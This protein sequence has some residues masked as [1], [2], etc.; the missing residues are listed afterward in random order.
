M[1]RF[2]RHLLLGTLLIISTTSM[3]TAQ[4]NNG[5]KE[6]TLSE[7]PISLRLPLQKEVIV[8]FP[9]PVTHTDLQDQSKVNAFTNLLTPDG[10][11]Y[12]RAV[13]AF[14]PTR[15]IAQLVDGRLVMLDVSGATMGPYDGDLLIRDPAAQPIAQEPAKNPYKP[16]FLED[17]AAKTLNMA[18]GDLGGAATV[19]S[20]DAEFHQMVRYGFRHFVGP[21]RLI[22][23]DLGKPVKVGKSDVA[24]TLLRMNDGRLSVKAL[25]QWEIGDYYLTVLLVNN[26]SPSAVEFDP[27]TIRGRWVFAAALY[28]V[29]EARGS[30]FDQTLWALIS[31]VPFDKARQ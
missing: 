18:E 23:D 13:E 31:Q 19:Q 5:V 1:K 4:Q 28:P 22:G 26:K 3:T 20:G 10:V 16:A 24:A 29:L 30:R 17:G 7:K 21:A 12:L 9:Q 14:E 8:R 27:R 15:M 11:L 6:I 2:L 25:K